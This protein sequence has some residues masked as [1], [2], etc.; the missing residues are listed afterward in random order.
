MAT[1]GTTAL[2]LADWGKRTENG[3]VAP[4]IEILNQSNEILD[5]MLW[6]EGN[7]PTG[8]KT[9]IRSGLPNATW[10]LLNYGV[11]PSKSRTVQVTDTCGMLETYCEIDKSLAD[12]N[13]NGAEFRLSEDAPFVEAMNQQFASTLFYGNTQTDP[14]KF[15]GLAAR[16]STKTVANANSADNV[17]DGGGTAS[18]N[19]S[20]WLIG[21]SANTITGIFPKGSKAG[22]MH[23]DL[24]EHTLFDANGGR[25]Q[26]YRSH[27]KWDSGL[28]VRDWRYAVRIANIDVTTLTKA[29]TAGADLIDLL[30][31]ALERIHSLSGC[32]PVFYGNRLIKSF[33]RRQISNKTLQS[34]L[35]MDTVAG[36]PVM[37]FADVPFRRVDVL[38]STEAQVT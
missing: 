10:R 38:L 3:K 32:T 33:L 15:L 13:G 25:Y 20:I 23:E 34:T 28:T 5:D 24:G 9:T 31:Q 4:I 37:T 30:T 16:Y 14:E 2:T 26:G 8:H 17:L 12:L 35:A 11:Q 22:L 6:L 19:T 21:W 7:L 36:K 1:L 18:T 29:N 27:Y